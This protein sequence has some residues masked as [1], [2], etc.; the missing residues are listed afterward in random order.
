MSVLGSKCPASVCLSVKVT[1]FLLL[2]L[3]VKYFAAFNRLADVI[4]VIK[5]SLDSL[6]RGFWVVF[7]TKAT[8]YHPGVADWRQMLL[9]PVIPRLTVA[10]SQAEIANLRQ[11]FPGSFF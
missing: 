9:R 7:G 10:L 11:N 3:G 4:C 8:K 2:K 6:D 5:F 1:A